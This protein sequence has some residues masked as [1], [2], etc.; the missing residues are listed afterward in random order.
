M[1]GPARLERCFLRPCL[2]IAAWI[3]VGCSSVTRTLGEGTPVPS[4]GDAGRPV[5]AINDTA[6]DSS[7]TLTADLLEIYFAS[8]RG[9]A[10]QSDL[11]FATRSSR[12]DAF[13]APKPIENLNTEETETSPAIS[14]DG[15]TLWFASDRAGGAG[16]LDIWQSTRSARDADWGAP[17]NVAELN[18]SSDDLP[19]PPAQDGLVMPFTSQRDA[20]PAYQT[21]LA[22]RDTTGSA[23]G[24]ITPVSELWQDGASMRDAFLT[25]DGLLLFFDLEN[26][27]SGDL[28][29]AWRRS[30]QDP[31][32]P[33]LRLD[34]VNTDANEQAPW[35]NTDGTR[36]F[37]GSARRP[38]T[39]LDIYAT[40]LDL[41][42]F[43]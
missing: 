20:A 4:F 19:R 33:A 18:G 12:A 23:F 39:G 42:R 21:Y 40:T 38:E 24:E 43:E 14:L 1:M 36:F 22:R 26:N 13:D 10:G 25:E 8:T 6:D 7:P 15:L 16:G 41:P 29:M 37:F 9:A 28:Y 3:G 32:E 30:P 5:A 17:V 34:A 27:G 35:V 11:W 31:F 2:L